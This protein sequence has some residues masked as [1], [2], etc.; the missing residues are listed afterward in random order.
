MHECMNSHHRE[1][2]ITLY[3]ELGPLEDLGLIQACAYDEIDDQVGC[4]CDAVGAAV[5]VV[6]GIIRGLSL[7]S[8][9]RMT[10]TALPVSVCVHR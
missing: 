9:L 6:S 8:W 1:H 3:C 10:C 7:F 4:S 2:V 5:A